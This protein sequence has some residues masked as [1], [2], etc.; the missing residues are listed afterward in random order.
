ME[1]SKPKIIC[2]TSFSSSCLFDIFFSRFHFFFPDNSFSFTA[3][4][5]TKH[6]LSL[7]TDFK[8]TTSHDQISPASH[9]IENADAW[10]FSHLQKHF[11]FS[12]STNTSFWEH[13]CP[14]LTLKKKIKNLRIHS[15]C[16][17]CWRYFPL[18]LTLVSLKWLYS[19]F[20]P[21]ASVEEYLK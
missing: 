18:S 2:L 6:M 3:P 13:S 21:L 1:G 8:V 17:V 15:L 16:S 20:M 9:L 5:K 7:T 12:S 19:D 4:P 14:F 11:I 10:A